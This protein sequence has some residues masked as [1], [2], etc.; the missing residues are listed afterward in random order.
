MSWL[1]IDNS[2]S[3]T[4]FALGTADSLTGWRR[5]LP[6]ADISPTT[7]EPLLDGVKFR[8]VLLC[9]VVPAKAEVMRSSFPA[10]M[11]FHSMSAASRLGISID[12]PQPSQIGADRLA[13]AVAVGASQDAPAIVIDFGTAVT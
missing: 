12:Y 13:N 11:S 5:W 3:R 9:S 1:L 7:L 8:G 2:N 6:T 10:G 4:K